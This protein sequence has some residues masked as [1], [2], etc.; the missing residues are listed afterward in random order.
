MAYQKREEPT[1]F[2]SVFATLPVGFDGKNLIDGHLPSL[3][4]PNSVLKR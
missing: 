1:F 2:F 3:S 4:A